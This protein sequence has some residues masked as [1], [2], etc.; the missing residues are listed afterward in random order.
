[1]LSSLSFFVI[2]V[3]SEFFPGVYVALWPVR[4]S[5]FVSALPQGRSWGVLLTGNVFS[6][7][8]FFSFEVGACCIVQAGLIHRLPATNYFT[9]GITS[10][11]TWFFCKTTKNTFTGA[12]GTFLGMHMGLEDSGWG[13]MFSSH[14]CLSSSSMADKHLD[15]MIQFTSLIILCLPS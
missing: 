11:M 13:S 2:W 7:S 9:A 15:L 8:Y 14:Y 10:K 12:E 5:A 6:R 4:V 3:L 1:M